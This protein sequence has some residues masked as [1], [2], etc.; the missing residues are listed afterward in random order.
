M[1]KEQTA[2]I[3][4][5]ISGLFMA[6]LG[7]VFSHISNSQSIYL[8]GM[9]SLVNMAMATITLIVSR[10]VIS[11]KSER[12]QFGI[13]Q[14]E[15]ILNVIKAFIFIGILLFA[16]FLAI[17][18]IA[19][20]GRAMSFDSGVF[21]AL[22]AAVGCFFTSFLISLVE[23]NNKSPMLRVERKAW[24]VDGVLSSAVLLVFGA[25]YLIKGT[26]LASYS[27]YIDPV[28]MILLILL[29]IPIP[30][31]IFKDNF[32]D[33]LFSA[34]PK[35]TIQAIERHIDAE[36]P[37]SSIEDYYFRTAKLGRF[38]SIHISVL[39]KKGKNLGAQVLDGIRIK[40]DTSIN[41]EIPNSII[42]I[43]TT[44]DRQIYERINEQ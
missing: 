29:V 6:T 24:F 23:R 21:Y 4:S 5:I 7:F 14:A 28:T 10:K 26:N 33:L 15:P 36:L 32:N 9:F 13:G 1:K 30:I 41:S 19:D 22:I 27:D 20:G 31:R 17:Q 18:A 44:M 34:P 12:F 25:G 16:F 3:I 37:Q 38:H 2:Y 11:Y 35:E 8:D 39:V 43:E 40:L 42:A